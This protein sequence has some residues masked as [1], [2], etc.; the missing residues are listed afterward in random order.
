MLNYLLI[1]EIIG[2][3]LQR[4]R[5]INFLPHTYNATALWWWVENIHGYKH[6]THVPKNEMK[7]HKTCCQWR[8]LFCLLCSLK[9]PS[10][11]FPPCWSFFWEICCLWR[12][13][14]RQWW[15]Q[16]WWKALVKLLDRQFHV[17]DNMSEDGTD[18][19][20]AIRKMMESLA[21]HQIL[22]LNNRMK[23]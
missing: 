9:V 18:F 15:W 13:W 19:L 1:H 21:I 20:F 5:H 23:V 12:S 7:I 8:T 4:T 14:W 11:I 6:E 2:R 3:L 17:V 22:F 16:Q 10:V